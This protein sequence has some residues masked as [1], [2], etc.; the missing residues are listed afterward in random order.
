ML[1]IFV[2]GFFFAITLYSLAERA[3]VVRDTSIGNALDE[4][5]VLMKQNFS[6]CLIMTMIFIGLGIGIGIV[7][8]MV[9]GVFFFPINMLVHSISESKIVIFV[10]ALILGLPISLVVGGFIGTFF[11]SLYTLFYFGLVDPNS[12]YA[13]TTTLQPPAPTRMRRRG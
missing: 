7:V 3:L 5:Y 10:L 6:K 9:A 4:G 2:A 11:H 1:P 12:P 8:L 13:K